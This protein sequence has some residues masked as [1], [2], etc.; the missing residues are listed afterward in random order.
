MFF[1]LSIAWKYLLPRRR[2]LSVSIISLI[3]ILVIALVI[4]L[5]LVFFSVTRGL[6][7]SWIDKLVS[8]TAPIR[9]TPTEAYYHSYYYQVDQFSSSTEYGFRTIAEKERA[10]KSDPY[11]VLIDEEL[12]ESFPQPDLENGEVKDLVKLAFAGI[13]AVPG[14]SAKAYAVT[15]ANLR[16]RLVRGGFLEAR[17]SFLTQPIYLGTFEEENP[18]YI[19]TFLP[20][21]EQDLGNTLSLLN[22]RNED[23]ISDAPEA[24]QRMPR[25]EAEKRLAL[26]QATAA[27]KNFNEGE[28]TPFYTIYRQQ[29]GKSLVYQLPHDPVAGYGMVAP[30]SFRTAGVLVG[31]RGYISYYAPTASTLQEQRIPMFIAGFYDPGI[32]P[33]GG[34][35]LLADAALVQT[36][37]AAQ[38]Q[39]A[40]LMTNGI[41]IRF[42]PLTQAEEIKAKLEKE[43]AERDIAPYWKVE[44]FREF[45]YAKEL[46]QQLSSEKH[47]FTLI[48]GVI[49]IVACS[50]IISMLIILVNNKRLEIGILRSMGASSTSIALIFGLCGMAMGIVGSL[51]GTLLAFFTLRHLDQLLN[52]ISHLQGYDAFNPIFYGGNLPNS[53]SYETLLTVIMVTACISLIAGLIPALKA[54]RLK[55]A[56]ILRSE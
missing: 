5:I 22:V 48:S 23:E 11:N 45:E 56:L 35:F 33:L 38:G 46:L 37:R 19:K 3:S 8:L 42:E 12:P 52:L 47:I 32:V 13:N 44:T 14:I 30:K 34:K 49:I 26:F 6:E 16:L 17:Q 51:L 53:M 28:P 29:K 41:N 36:V 40:A 27:E 54:S 20:L 55:P 39:E 18:A 21:T 15:N 10:A 31:D 50:N 9:V 4:W 25:K 2:Q 7:K 1:E 24:L 43:F